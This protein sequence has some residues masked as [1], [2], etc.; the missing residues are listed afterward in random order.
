MV[1]GNPALTGGAGG[2]RL[3]ASIG[4]ADAHPAPPVRAGYERRSGCRQVPR[5]R[6]GDTKM[7]IRSRREFLKTT[8]RS[9]TALGATGALGKFGEINALA[10]GANYQALVCIFL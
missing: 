4:V 9:V 3:L 5:F 1:I 2:C 6:Q 8:L 7:L 10:A